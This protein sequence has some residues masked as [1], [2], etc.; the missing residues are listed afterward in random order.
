M[1]Q[2]T[3][4]LLL[5]AGKRNSALAFNRVQN[6]RLQ[7][8]FSASGQNPDEKTPFMADVQNWWKV[9][10]GRAPPQHVETSEIFKDSIAQTLISREFWRALP[11]ILRNQPNPEDEEKEPSFRES[12]VEFWKDPKNRNYSLALIALILLALAS[13][14]TIHEMV[15]IEFGAYQ[16]I[17]LSVG[18]SSTVGVG[19]F[20]SFQPNRDG[21]ADQLYGWIP[22]Q[23]QS[24]DHHQRRPQVGV[25]RDQP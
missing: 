6:V 9:L 15:G 23:L 20:A 11:H 7:R 14:T 5:R 22:G 25:Q 10:V 8:M 13:S 16:V 12:F 21:E 4:G 2:R 24:F 18:V 3:T 17:P 19:E 1:L